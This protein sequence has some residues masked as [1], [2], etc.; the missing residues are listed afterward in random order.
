MLRD[1]FKIFIGNFFLG[2]GQVLL[3]DRVLCVY[4]ARGRQLRSRRIILGGKNSI[5]R[6]QKYH[7]GMFLSRQA[8][9][10]WGGGAPIESVKF[11]FFIPTLILAYMHNLF[12]DM[13]LQCNDA[14]I[15]SK[16]LFTKKIEFS[17]ITK[18]IIFRNTFLV[19]KRIKRLVFFRF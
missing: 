19:E 12:Q 2:G 7:L 1:T 4:A 8:I 14:Y 16:G 13:F 9:Y 6:F 3:S 15:I 5:R 18:Q 11:F 10:L 17:Q